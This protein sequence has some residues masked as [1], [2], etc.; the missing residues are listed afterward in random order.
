MNFFDY[1]VDNWQLLLDLTIEHA[2]LVLA[3][4][5]VASVVGVS[6]AVAVYRHRGAR[7]VALRGTGLIL[8][9][10]SL[11]MYAVLITIPLLGIG[12]TSVL[13][14]LSLYALMP[15]VRNTVTGLLGVDAAIVES[16]QGM[17]MNRWQRLWRIEMPMAWPVVMTGIR[18]SLLLII[19]IAALGAIING[20]GLGELIFR[21]LSGAGRP[22]ALPVALAGFLGVVVLAALLDALFGLFARLTTS[23]GLR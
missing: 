7:E 10:P 4:V 12:T 8:T 13:V 22:F 2:L 16:A 15:I 19:G 11:A 5:A 21:G 3:A 14:A 1:L 23:R 20:P 17:G 9:V 18:L 6:L